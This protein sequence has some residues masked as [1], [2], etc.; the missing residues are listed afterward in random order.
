MTKCVLDNTLNFKP[1]FEITWIFL[2]EFIVEEIFY[3]IH[4]SSSLF[5]GNCYRG[6]PK[7]L[8]LLFCY[9]FL[10]IG[11]SNGLSQQARLIA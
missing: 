7:Y 3:D 5:G 2:G 9:E 1:F 8:G 6:I 11:L 10:V 4:W